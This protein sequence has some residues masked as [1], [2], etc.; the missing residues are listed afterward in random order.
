SL[1]KEEL[2]DL[3]VAYNTRELATNLLGEIQVPYPKE[4]KGDATLEEQEEYQRQVD[5]YSKKFE[6][7]FKPQLIRRVESL[8]KSL[9]KLSLEELT[10]AYERDLIKE[11]CNLRHFETYREWCILFGTYQDKD[12][13]TRL[14]ESYEQF[15]E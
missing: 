13:T 8:K 10:K 7:A 5:G 12:M 1:N 14:F 9:D 4:P 3:I 11:A 15:K 2:V 6:E